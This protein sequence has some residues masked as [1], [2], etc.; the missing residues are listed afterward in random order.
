[1]GHCEMSKIGPKALQLRA[2]R[3]A[4]EAG[5]NVVALPQ[6]G[7]LPAPFE[8]D[9]ARRAIKTL[10]K[11]VQLAAEMREW[12]EAKE[13]ISLMVGWQRDFVA[14]WDVH[15]G[16][17]QSPGRGGLKKEHDV[18]G[19]IS[20]ADAEKQTKIRQQQV[21]HWRT[22][23]KRPDYE[24][25]LFNAAQRKAMSDDESRAE[26]VT[27]EAEWYTPAVYVEKCRRVLGGIDLDPA[28]SAGAQRTVK[29]KAFYTKE[30]DGLQQ[31]WK[32]TVF[33]NP[34]YGSKLIAAFAA[35]LL[36]ELAAGNVTGAVMLTNGYTETSWFHNL[37]KPAAALCFTS[38]RIKF[39]SPEEEKASPTNGQCFFYFGRKPAKFIAEFA[40]VGLVLVHP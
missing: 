18:L 1:M 3:E 6:R 25:R 33:L 39:I 28:S 38:G 4:R 22:G 15:V 40:D 21:S 7:S 34:P 26:L 13:A 8:P 23:L 20:K 12:G 17:R 16:V 30:A 5:S 14:W 19:S 31:T 27:G 9:T 10:D 11:A 37:G 29:A 2:L 24:A 32:G 35:K 36:E